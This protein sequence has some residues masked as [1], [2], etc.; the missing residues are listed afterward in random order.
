MLD[1]KNSNF[2]Y[3]VQNSQINVIMSCHVMIYEIRKKS[4]IDKRR[5][6]FQKDIAEKG[7]YAI[8]NPTIMT[9]YHMH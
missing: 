2:T 8:L 1:N 9:D 4:K 3:A 7:M 5:M 6:V